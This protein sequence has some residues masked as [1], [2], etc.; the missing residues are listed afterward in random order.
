LLRHFQTSPCDALPDIWTTR[1]VDDAVKG[2]SGDPG[3]AQE[4]WI[5]G[6]AAHVTCMAYMGQV[7]KGKEFDS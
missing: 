7:V 1:P 3:A 4:R 2:P 5:A 6:L